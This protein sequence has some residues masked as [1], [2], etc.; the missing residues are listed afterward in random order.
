MN[1]GFIIFFWQS[2]AKIIPR[3]HSN[4][5]FHD[6][7]ITVIFTHSNGI[8]PGSLSRSVCWCVQLNWAMVQFNFGILRIWEFTLCAKLYNW[9]TPF[10]HWRIMAAFQ[11]TGRWII[12]S[13]H[14]SININVEVLLWFP[15]SILFWLP[16][17]FFPRVI[18]QHGDCAACPDSLSSLSP[19]KMHTCWRKMIFN[20]MSVLMSVLLR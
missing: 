19:I 9:Q 4:W 18:C 16:W 1:P 11:T 5:L 8:I 10:G 12:V 13:F 2:C 20:Q 6:Y 14:V 17:M 3:K 7:S 15:S